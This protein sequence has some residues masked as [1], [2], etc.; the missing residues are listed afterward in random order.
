MWIEQKK[1]ITVICQGMGKNAFIFYHRFWGFVAS[2]SCPSPE[3]VQ[4]I[5]KCNF[6]LILS[7]QATPSQIERIIKNTCGDAWG[8]ITFNYKWVNNDY[9]CRGA[10]I[11][12]CGTEKG[13]TKNG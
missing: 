12:L 3:E 13:K 9:I 4:K 8:K 10:K 1:D 5:G 11:A 2:A 6:T 7:Q